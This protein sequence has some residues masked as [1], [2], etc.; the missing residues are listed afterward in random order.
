MTWWHEAIKL[1]AAAALGSGGTLMVQRTDKRLDRRQRRQDAE[2]AKAPDFALEH[3]T[4]KRYRLVNTGTDTA[5]NVHFD[6]DTTPPGLLIEPPE[7]VTLPPD[8]A[9]G[10]L[11]APD[12]DTPMPTQLLVRC[13]ELPDPTVVLVPAG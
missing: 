6:G 5:T 13:S 3:V 8:R 10:F 11:M 1:T 9:H 12:Y 4:K 2:A 7:N